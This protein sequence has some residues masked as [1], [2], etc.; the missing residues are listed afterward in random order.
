MLQQ[1]HRSGEF[2]AAAPRASNGSRRPRRRARSRWSASP[3]ALS[4]LRPASGA[5]RGGGRLAEAGR[6]RPG[7]ENA[8]RAQGSNR[9]PRRVRRALVGGYAA[10]CAMG[11]GLP[12]LCTPPSRPCAP[13]SDLK[14]R[15]GTMKGANL[16][17]LRRSG[18]HASP[19]G[20]GGYDK[21]K[22]FDSV[23]MFPQR[24]IS[25]HLRSAIWP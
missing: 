4:R 20:R 19:L 23:Q 7:Y 11:P 14:P 1:P 21:S 17:T 5:R 15:A 10:M 13:H 3:G 24:V 2:P 8:F 9:A 18:E 12:R 16:P 6:R 25:G 22:T